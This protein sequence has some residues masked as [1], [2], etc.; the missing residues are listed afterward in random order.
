MF[1]SRYQRA[2]VSLVSQRYLHRFIKKTSS[3]G[4]M[5]LSFSP[6]YGFLHLPESDVHVEFVH[7]HP[8]ILA[9]ASET[10]RVKSILMFVPGNPGLV[11]FYE[12]FLLHIQEERPNI[13]VIGIGLTGHSSESKNNGRQF[14]LPEQVQH[15]VEAIEHLKATHP[16]AKFYL[17]GHS[18]GSFMI[19]EVLRIASD[20][21]EL[22]RCFLLFPALR[23]LR[24]QAGAINVLIKPGFRHLV[25]GIGGF[26]S[27]TP[28][29]FKRG[30]VKLF[31]PKIK[32]CP[33]SVERLFSYSTIMNI[34]Y[35]TVTEFHIVRHLDHQTLEK[36]LD[37]IV[38]YYT[39]DD[40]WVPIEFFEDVKSRFPKHEHIYLDKHGV[41]HAFCLED[42][43]TI[44]QEV[45]P[46]L[47]DSDKAG[48][49]EP[50]Q[51]ASDPLTSIALLAS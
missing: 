7:F 38:F 17:A 2:S 33:G 23:H 36:H 3:N 24:E 25:A 4:T 22:A 49:E 13:G 9:P 44:A 12:K 27:W 42:S 37:K 35:L 48:L 50:S 15:K 40:G 32:D 21:F 31:G 5:A 43:K 26:I 10:E 41:K 47:H 39:K 34:L 46:F 30:L 6:V 16:D 51:Q 14:S 1:I 8:R 19:K 29:V 11:H 45:L 20:R 18:I 28:N